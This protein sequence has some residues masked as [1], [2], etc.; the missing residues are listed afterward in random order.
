MDSIIEHTDGLYLQ[1]LTY[2]Q[3]QI[4]TYGSTELTKRSWR[5]QLPPIIVIFGPIGGCY[6]F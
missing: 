3:S 4:R 5:S 2:R 1:G 6:V